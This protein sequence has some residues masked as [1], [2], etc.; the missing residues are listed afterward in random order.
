MILGMHPTKLTQV[1]VFAVLSIAFLYKPLAG[2]TRTFTSAEGV[3]IEAELLSVDPRE[4]A[5]IRRA[6]GRL[7]RDVP[8]DFFSDADRKYIRKWQSDKQKALDTANITP[9]SRV[10]ISVATSR[11][12]D[13]NNYGD[14]DDQIIQYKPRL[15]FLNE[16][17][18]KTFTGVNGTLVFIGEH[19]L[20]GSVNGALYREDFKVNIPPKKKI[21]WDGIPFVT[22]YDPDWGGFKYEGYLLVVRD[23]KG[24]V[25]QIKAS[26]SA[27]EQNYKKILKVPLNVPHDRK[28]ESEARGYSVFSM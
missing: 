8:I 5:T 23:Q 19:V 24:E 27:W 28:F 16:E 25:V 9:D 13:L 7:F 10:R 2:E 1:F 21:E 3:T 26:K 17:M 22:K 14:I 15:S 18:Q 11:D 20:D 12:R 6:D 4:R